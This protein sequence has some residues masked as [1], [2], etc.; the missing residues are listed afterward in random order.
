MSFAAIVILPVIAVLC[1]IPVVIGVYVYRDAK[2]RRMNAVL[3]TIVAAA[4]PSLIGFIIYLLVRGSYSDL[5]CPQCGTA[6]TGEYIVCPGCGA[7]LRLSCPGCAAPVEPDWAVC[8]HCAAPLP[9]DHGDVVTPVH[10][11]DKTLW[12]LLAVIVAVP[13]LLIGLLTVSFSAASGSGT[14]SMHEI[15]FDDYFSQQPSDDIHINVIE[16]LAGLDPQPYRAYALQYEIPEAEGGGYS[17]LIFVPGAGKQSRYSFGHGSGLLGERVSLELEYTGNSDSLF[18]VGLSGG[19]P[20]RLRIKLS[21]KKIPC[22]VTEV[23]FDPAIPI[24]P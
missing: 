10:R 13:I 5:E 17:C 16:W 19:N 9:A 8:P 2:R 20:P 23:L 14:A 1:V 24:T 22:D 18:C 3:W 6:V 15:S 12:K 11:Q 4:A 21:G 7:K